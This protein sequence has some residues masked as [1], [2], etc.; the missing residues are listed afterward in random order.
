M[1]NNHQKP[2]PT[3]RELYPWATEEELEQIE[4]TLDQYAW[5]L[6]D[7]KNSFDADPTKWDQFRELVA[8]ERAQERLDAEY[9]G[10]IASGND[11][12]LRGMPNGVLRTKRIA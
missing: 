12:P 5:F 3:L 10:Y 9:P 4:F 7:L 11:D 1:N 8:V 2:V 6:R